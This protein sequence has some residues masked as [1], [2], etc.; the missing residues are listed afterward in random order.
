[1]DL[2]IIEEKI[3]LYAVAIISVNKLGRALIYILLNSYDCPEFVV[4][5]KNYQKICH[6]GEGV[7]D[8]GHSKSEHF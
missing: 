6:V 3:S 7:A 2:T 5:Y 1:M 4:E 8:P